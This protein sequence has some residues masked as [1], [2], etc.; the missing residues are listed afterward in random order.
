[1]MKQGQQST[2]KLAAL[3]L[4][5]V[6]SGG[7]TVVDCCRIKHWAGE[8]ATNFGCPI[9]CWVCG[10]RGLIPSKGQVMLPENKGA[11]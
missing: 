9:A 8:I 3:L 2:A 6:T 10:G 11:G 1:M 7:T 5:E 4:L